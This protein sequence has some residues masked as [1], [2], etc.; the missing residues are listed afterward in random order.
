[1]DT[2]LQSQLAYSHLCFPRTVAAG[3]ASPSQACAQ[4]GIILLP[5]RMIDV[6]KGQNKRSILCHPGLWQVFLADCSAA[7][8]ARAIHTP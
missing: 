8:H 6:G 7:G 1:M 3:D 2:F 5:N 4:A